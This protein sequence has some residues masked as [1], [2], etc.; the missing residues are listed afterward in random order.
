MCDCWQ[1]TPSDDL[2]L[3]EIERIFRQLP[4]MDAV[5]LTGGEPFLRRDLP[6][7]AQLVERFL[8][9]AV[10]HITT[11]GFLGDRI[12][13]FCEQ[14]NRR[15]PLR[16]LVSL[17]GVGEKHNQVRG[18][19]HAW[20]ATFGT[21]HSLAARRRE[22][23][24]HLMVNQ[25]VVDAD[26]LEQHRALRAR[27]RPLGVPVS[28]VIGYRQSA[29]YSLRPDIDVSPQHPAD[30]GLFGTLTPA[31][32]EALLREAEEAA[33][34]LGLVERLARRYYLRGLRNR[35]L[36]REASPQPPCVALNAHL[37]LNPEGTVP[38]C[39][40][41]SRSVGNLRHQTFREV[42]NATPRAEARAWVRRCP[43]C[44]AECEVVPNAFYTGDWAR[45]WP[46]QRPSVTE[47]SVA[48]DGPATVSPQ[49]VTGLMPG[50]AE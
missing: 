13:T 7:I 45:L 9:P 49:P 5:R 43:G 6:E 37:R 18:R 41:N 33:G 25:V 29:T 35:L 21:L 42:W 17:D 3:P 15:I 32:L 22:L 46:R 34:E 12:R 39:Q 8:H 27:L 31:E 40:F 38:I 26:G 20:D 14:R 47:P 10:L 28:M 16:L 23:G 30:Y 50:E 44:W 11:N 4:R 48:T 1:K 19:P 24:L 36:H 2:S